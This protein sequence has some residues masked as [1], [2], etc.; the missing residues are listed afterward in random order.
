MEIEKT[1]RQI[2]LITLGIYILYSTSFFWFNDIKPKYQDCGII[3]S[4]S[5]D[6][7]ISQ[8]FDD[9][10]KYIQNSDNILMSLLKYSFLIR[11]L[12]NNQ[13]IVYSSLMNINSPI[14]FHIA[15]Q[16]LSSG[17]KPES[18]KFRQLTV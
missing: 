16:A 8:N 5:T 4:K 2:I 14:N 18:E 12:S 9:I 6:K 7:Q 1:F 17:F 15:T 13:I 10:D 11:Y 3:L